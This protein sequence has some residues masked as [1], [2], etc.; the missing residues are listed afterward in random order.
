M[1]H[2]ERGSK[3]RPRE[4]EEEANIIFEGIW[5]GLQ[6]KW[7]HCDPQCEPLPAA[8]MSLKLL[9][10]QSHGGWREEQPFMWPLINSNSGSFV[11]MC[12]RGVIVSQ[13]NYKSTGCLRSCLPLFLDFNRHNLNFCSCCL[14]VL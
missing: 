10:E 1:E 11:C 2:E 3:G 5:G 12:S 6:R 4:D 7:P 8:D 9:D 14:N 13:S